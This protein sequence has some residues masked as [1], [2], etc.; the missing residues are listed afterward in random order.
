[1]T[2]LTHEASDAQS[3]KSL[4]STFF[5]AINNVDIKALENCFTDENANLVILR[6]DPPRQPSASNYPQYRS[7]PTT[8][9]K[10]GKGEE[11]I[12]VV[13]RTSIEKFISLIRD[14]EKR[15]RGQPHQPILHESPDL[16]GTDMRI[17]KFFA[18]VWS[19]FK[20]TFDG[21]LHHY[22]S[23]AYTVVKVGGKEWKIEGLTQNYRRTPGW[24]VPG[25]GGG[26]KL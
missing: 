1:M 15:R 10:D 17:D 22:G 8:K 21:V 7:V 11:K 9:E 5:D 18:Q 2:Q 25:E 24:E 12:E 14:G 23:L 19:P 20:V 3:I 6:Q 16:D 13:I 26:G 4:I